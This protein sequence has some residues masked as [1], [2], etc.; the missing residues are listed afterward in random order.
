MEH[1]YL[2]KSGLRVSSIGLGTMGFGGGGKFAVVGTNGVDEAKSQI[3]LCLDAGVDLVDTAD[4]YSGGASE[5]IVGE[6]IKGRRDRIVLATKARFATGDGPNDQGLS[7]H[8]L[9][10]ACEASLRR[11]D[12]DYI[13]LF[14][15]HQ[16]DG[17][18]PLEETLGALET[19]VQQ[20][21]I[22]YV[23][24]SNFSAW[25]IMKALGVADHRHLPR[26]VS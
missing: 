14:Q 2:G 15:V 12:V 23:G 18:T 21:K 20:G 11:L 10:A 9:I 4:A 5:Q 17:M 25:H 22:R 7:R 19:L 16:W 13:D 8:H 24:C 1:R 3:D 26:F 6:A